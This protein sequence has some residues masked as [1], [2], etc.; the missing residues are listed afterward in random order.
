M[1]NKSNH[2]KRREDKRD[3]KHPQ[4]VMK[5]NA[6]RKLELATKKQLKNIKRG[7]KGHTPIKRKIISK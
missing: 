3:R 4:G 2:D 7:R 5:Y 6:E 1:A